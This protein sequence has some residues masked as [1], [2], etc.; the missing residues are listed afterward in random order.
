MRYFVKCK[1]STCSG[2]VFEKLIF[3]KFVKKYVAFYETRRFI[4]VFTRARHLPQ[5]RAR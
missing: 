4:I 3:P 1:L 2:V 5:S